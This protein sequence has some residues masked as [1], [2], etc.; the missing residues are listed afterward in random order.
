MS[1]R[2]GIRPRSPRRSSRRPA[3]LARPSRCLRA[4]GARSARGR[5]SL[6]VCGVV[7]ALRSLSRLPR[8]R[9]AG[10]RRGAPGRVDQHPPVPPPPPAGVGGLRP[11]PGRHPARGSGRSLGLPCHAVFSRWGR[12]RLRR[13]GTGLSL[14]GKPVDGAT[15]PAAGTRGVPD[16]GGTRDCYQ[17]FGGPLRRWGP[18]R[19]GPRAPQGARLRFPLR[20]GLRGDASAVSPPSLSPSRE[21]GTGMGRSRGPGRRAS[22]GASAE[23]VRNF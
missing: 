17:V 16:V 7:V 10:P 5:L 2:D 6:Q 14:A 18:G 15:G 13:L 1:P 8:S 4:V 19:V 22:A 20:S 3:T 21:S 11:A 12:D 9:R 23:L